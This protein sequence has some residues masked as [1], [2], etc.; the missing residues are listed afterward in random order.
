MME[1]MRYIIVGGISFYLGMVLTG[2]FF[3]WRM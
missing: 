1:V 2:W 3:M